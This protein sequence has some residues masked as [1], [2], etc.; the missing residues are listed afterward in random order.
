M[1]SLGKFRCTGCKKRAKVTVSK[2]KAP[3]PVKTAGEY[4]AASI[5]VLKGMAPAVKDNP[6]ITDPKVIEALEA[7]PKAEV[8][9]A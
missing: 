3:E 6:Y 8:L 4:S 1:Q 2:Y 5:E 7:L 9:N